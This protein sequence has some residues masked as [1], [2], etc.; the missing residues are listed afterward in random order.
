VIIKENKGVADLFL[1]VLPKIKK[2]QQGQLTQTPN[3]LRLSLQEACR[4][5][6]VHEILSFKS[7]LV[8]ADVRPD[9]VQILHKE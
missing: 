4:S 6:Q 2:A 5:C 7:A 3:I 9:N 1:A 8:I